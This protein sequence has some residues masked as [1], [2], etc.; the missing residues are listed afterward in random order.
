MKRL[1]LVGLSAV[2]L[3]AC[4]NSDN[5]NA[6]AAAE[7]TAAPGG[8]SVTQTVPPSV[9]GSPPVVGGSAVTVPEQ[10]PTVDAAIPSAAA[11][12]PAQCLSMQSPTVSDAVASLP[13][14]FDGVG[15]V[16]YAMGDPCASFTWV[17]ATAP[18]ATASTPDH[19][20]FFADGVYLGTATAEPYSFS[21]VSGQTANT[22]TIGYRWLVGDEAF[23]D[24]QGGPAVV[25][26]QWDGSTVTMLDTLPAE[27]TG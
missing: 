11:P 4:G 20:L 24:P 5:G 12:E 7:S 27:V 9:A 8:Q 16:A 15:W 13:S 3:V 26:Y 22:I 21:S 17:S 25:R 18:N 19:H 23:A 6:T 10:V 1:L 14:Y 2:A